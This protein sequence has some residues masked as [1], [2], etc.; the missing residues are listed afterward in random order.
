MMQIGAGRGRH[1]HGLI[2]RVDT[3]AA[4]LGRSAVLHG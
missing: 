3:L 2:D 1:I 4:E